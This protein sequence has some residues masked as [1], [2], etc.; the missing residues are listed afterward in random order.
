M[1]KID[2]ISK[3][4]YRT[5]KNDEHKSPFQNIA[6]LLK[7]LFSMFGLYKHLQIV[8]KIDH[9]SKNKNYKIE[10]SFVSVFQNIAQQFRQKEG[11]SS[12]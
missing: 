9:N 5:K 1:N 12:F 4:K 11:N 2:H 3:T 7:Y 10:F 6:H 8:N